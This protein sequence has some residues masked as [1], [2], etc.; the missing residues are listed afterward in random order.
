MML[1]PRL[2]VICY[3]CRSCLKALSTETM[4]AISDLITEIR[5]PLSQSINLM[6]EYYITLIEA[7][8]IEL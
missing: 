3:V 1:G 8:L 5:L 6:H 7:L 2:I 4:C